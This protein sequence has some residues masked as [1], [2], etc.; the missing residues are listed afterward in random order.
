M[1]GS[2]HA[3]KEGL[4]ACQQPQRNMNAN[5]NQ[6]PPLE[7]VNQLCQRE[8]ERPREWLKRIE[9]QL[10]LHMEPTCV[11]YDVILRWI[12]LR[13]TSTRYADKLPAMVS[14]TVESIITQMNK[15]DE[16]NPYAPMSRNFI[17]R[18]SLNGGFTGNARPRGKGLQRSASGKL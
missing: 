14:Q 2:F 13:G 5:L 4:Q 9:A 3:A 15:F 7:M 17:E 12:L 18:R 11:E 10:R 16:E 8:K 6:F 1:A